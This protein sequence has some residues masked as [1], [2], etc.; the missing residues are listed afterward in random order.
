[1]ICGGEQL[2]TIYA[3]LSQYAISLNQYINSYPDLPNAEHTLDRLYNVQ[4]L[5]SQL[6]DF[7]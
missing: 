7:F 2:D 1:M 5:L 4:E 3:A 6:D